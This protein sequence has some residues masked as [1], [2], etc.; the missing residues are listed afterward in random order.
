MVSENGGVMRTAALIKAPTLLKAVAEYMW[1][2]TE[3]QGL[4]PMWKIRPKHECN[5]GAVKIQ[6]SKSNTSYKK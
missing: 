3:I 4:T 1:F 2:I 5:E 6:L